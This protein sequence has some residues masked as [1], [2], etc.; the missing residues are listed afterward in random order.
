MTLKICSKQY[1]S[2]Y[3]FHPK[4]VELTSRDQ[5][6]ALINSICLGIV[7]LGLCQLVCLIKYRNRTFKLLSVIEDPLMALT[8]HAPR[9]GG[10]YLIDF[11]KINPGNIFK[12]FSTKPKNYLD[13]VVGDAWISALLADNLHPDFPYMYQLVVVTGAM[14]GHEIMYVHITFR[15]NTAGK[16]KFSGI[17]YDNLDD[18]IEKRLA[19]MYWC[20]FSYM[21]FISAGESKILRKTFREEL[22]KHL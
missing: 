13:V 3:I 7:T 1:F 21:D 20:T 11:T 2:N 10:A 4:A 22:Y 12:V 8:S 6:K 14:K 18:M 5:R 17:F 19:N 9:V 16:I 15:M